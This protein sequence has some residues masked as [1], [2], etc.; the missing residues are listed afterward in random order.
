MSGKITRGRQRIGTLFEL[1]NGA[2][3]D[4]NPVLRGVATALQGLSARLGS[5]GV[6]PAARSVA[7]AE[8]ERPAGAGSPRA[9]EG[10]AARAT[11]RDIV[12]DT[13]PRQADAVEG[14]RPVAAGTRPASEE[15]FLDLLAGTKSDA[16]RVWRCSADWMPSTTIRSARRCWRAIRVILPTSRSCA[17]QLL[18]ARPNWALLLLKSFDGGKFPKKD[19]TLDYAKTAVKL[20][21]KSVTAIVEKHFGK[22]APATAGEK[23]ARIGGLNTRAREREGRSASRQ[24]AVHQALRRVPHA[25]RRGRQG[26]AG[27]HDADR[28][29][30]RLSAHANRR[31]VRL[32]P[33]GVRRLYGADQGRAEVLRHRHGNRRIGHDRE[34]RERPGDE[35]DGCEGGYRGDGAVAQCRS[36]RKSSSTR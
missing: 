15:L 19:F 14:D 2:K 20:G 24:G 35:D 13:K 32:H 27:P 31:S 23:Q 34:R 8:T 17:I 21:D 33:A 28:K 16:I 11:L 6:P 3:D 26:R 12:A 25:P 30:T 10:R 18:L 9:H 36:C 22:L 29:N 7:E 5:S 1:T 4:I